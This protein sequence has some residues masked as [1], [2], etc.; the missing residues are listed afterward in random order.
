MVSSSIFNLFDFLRQLDNL[1]KVVAVFHTTRQPLYWQNWC[2]KWAY[3]VLKC[4]QKVNEAVRQIAWQPWMKALYVACSG[5]DRRLPTPSARANDH[6]LLMHCK[7]TNFLLASLILHADHSRWDA[8]EVCDGVPFTDKLHKAC[9]TISK[10]GYGCDA[11]FCC[12][13]I[14]FCSLHWQLTVPWGY[15]GTHLAELSHLGDITI[16]RTIAHLIFAARRSD[17]F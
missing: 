14:T 8:P 7:T 5:Y 6:S 4:F 1:L 9:L 12:T 11:D 17:S 10:T 13:R 15:F 16:F 3:S 2:C